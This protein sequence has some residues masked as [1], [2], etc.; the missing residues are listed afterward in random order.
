MTASRGI[1]LFQCIP[2]FMNRVRG[3]CTMPSDF[4]SKI[5]RDYL[6]MRQ[7]AL[8]QIHQFQ[9]GKTRGAARLKIERTLE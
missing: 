9:R 7:N 1:R 5:C 8:I 3:K 6:L 4:L 2:I